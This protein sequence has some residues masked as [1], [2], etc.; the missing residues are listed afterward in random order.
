MV[1]LPVAHDWLS[2]GEE[3]EIPKYRLN[4]IQV[5]HMQGDVNGP[6]RCLSDAF[7]W[8]LQNADNPTYE[9]LMTALTNTGNQKGKKKLAEVYGK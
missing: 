9:N 8:W 3:L 2:V 1:R 5:S 6:Q 4:V 7:E